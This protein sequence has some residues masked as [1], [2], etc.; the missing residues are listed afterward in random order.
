MM[1]IK[2]RHSCENP[3][4]IKFFPGT[5]RSTKNGNFS[6]IGDLRPSRNQNFDFV[7]VLNLTISPFF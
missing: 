2:L 1:L 7:L 5:K 4:K 3:G 6:S